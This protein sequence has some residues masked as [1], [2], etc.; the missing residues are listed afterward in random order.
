MAMGRQF[1]VNQVTIDRHFKF[2]AVGGND[3]ECLDLGLD[4]FIS[5]K[6]IEQAYGL[7]GVI[8]NATVLN[9]YV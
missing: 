9:R 7:R 8:S 5:Q 6:F 1:G 4:L 3:F 2:A